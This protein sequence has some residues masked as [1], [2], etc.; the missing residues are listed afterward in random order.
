M[1][2]NV[3]PWSSPA[4]PRPPD[5]PPRLPSVRDLAARVAKLEHGKRWVLASAFLGALSGDIV[6]GIAAAVGIEPGAL[7]SVIGG[8][9]GAL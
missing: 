9:L 5:E 6:R 2:G 4:T 7:A 3:L 8:I 1:L